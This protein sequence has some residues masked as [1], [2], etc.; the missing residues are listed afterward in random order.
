MHY[1]IC[2]FTDTKERHQKNSCV[3]RGSSTSMGPDLKNV[4]SLFLWSPPAK[5]E[6]ESKR[7]W[8]H[9][10]NFVRDIKYVVSSFKF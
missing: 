5:E 8:W 6:F 2:D 1:Y 9:C 7:W 4:G 10:R 3:E